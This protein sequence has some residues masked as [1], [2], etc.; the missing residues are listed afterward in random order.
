VSITDPTFAIME[1]D[2]NYGN[3]VYVFKFADI[4]STEYFRAICLY[5]VVKNSQTIK[6]FQRE[7][8]GEIS[9]D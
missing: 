2:S 8:G 5:N 4:E 3:S 1:T 6:I 7:D 9:V